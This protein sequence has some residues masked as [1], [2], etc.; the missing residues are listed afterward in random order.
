MITTQEEYDN[1]V[2]QVAR[3]TAEIVNLQSTV[4]AVQAQ[5]DEVAEL[6]CFDMVSDA[7]TTNI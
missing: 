7:P 2:T 4:D 1:C 6:Y 3:Q 5:I